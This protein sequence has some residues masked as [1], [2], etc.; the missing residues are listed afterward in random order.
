MD[1]TVEASGTDAGALEAL[2]NAT[3]GLKEN[4]ASGGLNLTI[5]DVK[6]EAPVQVVKIEDVNITAVIDTFPFRFKVR[7][8]AKRA[9]GSK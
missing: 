8:R 7:A 5:G 2:N 6:F 1:F 9:V 3:N 4:L